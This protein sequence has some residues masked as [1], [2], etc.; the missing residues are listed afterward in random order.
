MGDAVRFEDRR[1]AGRLLATRLLSMELSDPVVYALPRGGVPVAAEV[2]K[3]LHAP[4]DVL[5]VR[6][7]GAP[8]YP[9]FGVGAVIDGASPQVLLD[10]GACRA[11]GAT[12]PYVQGQVDVE[13]REIERRRKLFEKIGYSAVSPRG[14][15]AIVV[16]DGAA[17]GGTMA[18]AITALRQ[19]DA[20]RIIAALPV[21]P[22]ETVERLREG[23]DDVIC[24]ATPERFGSVGAFYDDFEQLTDDDVLRDLKLAW[25]SASAE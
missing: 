18:I 23:A 9:E 4:L 21:A 11:T 20:Y 7:I 19:R 6:K 1:E 22:G 24:L 16:D 2:A 14:R 12:T 15:T 25:Q 10:E 13:L 8:N 3:A 17:T 5:L